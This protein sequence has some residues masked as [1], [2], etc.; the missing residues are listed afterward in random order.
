MDEFGLDDYGDD[1]SDF[2]LGDGDDNLYD[3]AMDD[4]DELEFLRD[5]LTRVSEADPAAAAGLMAG[6]A[7]EP[8][9]KFETLMAG[10]AALV[11]READVTAQV[12]ALEAKKWNLL[13]KTGL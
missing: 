4:V 2:E 7:P 12:R 8:R 6:I 13:E 11:Q 10:V 9:A 1:D 5:T 3:A